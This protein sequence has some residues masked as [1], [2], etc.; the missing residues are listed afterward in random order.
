MLWDLLRKSKR[1]P[2]NVTT[3]NWDA[4]PDDLLQNLIK[5]DKMPKKG[6]SNNAWSSGPY[7]PDHFE[8]L[9]KKY[10]PENT[11]VNF[12]GYDEMEKSVK[13]ISDELELL[14]IVGA[15]KAYDMLRARAFKSDLWRWMALWS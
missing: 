9:A 1:Q 10:M 12:L 3:I 7:K 8:P 11:T 4:V 6:I 14:G 13:E 2:S 5:H 15:K